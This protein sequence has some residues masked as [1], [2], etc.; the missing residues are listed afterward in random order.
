MKYVPM[1]KCRLCGANIQ[2]A[3]GVKASKDE[4]VEVINKI[5]FMNNK[6]LTTLLDNYPDPQLIHHCRNG[7]IGIADFSGFRHEEY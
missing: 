4:V 7:S 5:Q 1:Y 2:V 3:K 6:G